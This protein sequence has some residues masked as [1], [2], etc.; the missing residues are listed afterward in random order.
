LADHISET[1]R[2]VFSIY[3]DKP[4]L[5]NYRQPSSMVV[6]RAVNILTSLKANNPGFVFP[7]GIASTNGSGSIGVEWECNKKFVYMGI[8]AD[9]DDGENDVIIYGDACSPYDSR[10]NLSME[11]NTREDLSVRR[12]AELLKRIIDA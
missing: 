9:N 4:N 2:D 8:E 6:C 5:P 3:I 7:E 11:S 10:G 12:L 1:V